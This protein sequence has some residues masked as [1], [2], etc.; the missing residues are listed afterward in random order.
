MLWPSSTIF[1]TPCWRVHSFSP[2]TK[3]SR[4][5]SCGWSPGNAGRPLRPA[6]RQS[7]LCKA[8]N[9]A[10]S[11]PTFLKKMPEPVP[12]PCTMTSAVPARGPPPS[13]DTACTASPGADETET[14]PRRQRAGPRSSRRSS[15]RAASGRVTDRQMRCQAN[16]MAAARACR[17]NERRA[18]VRAYGRR[19]RVAASPRFSA[20]R[21]LA[22]RQH[23][24]PVNTRTVCANDSTAA[25]KG[26]EPDLVC[27]GRRSES[28]GA[29]DA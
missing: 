5:R 13:T 11:G 9:D 12:R 17:D 15:A 26:C 8:P 24:C 21:R 18:R 3:K 16:D 10:A 28:A 14:S 27:E 25:Q 29:G 7:T 23:C 19:P 4:A 20:L 6:P 22:S 1:S 2:S